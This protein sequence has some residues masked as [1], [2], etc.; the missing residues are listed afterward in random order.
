[1]LTSHGKE[2][3]AAHVYIRG[4]GASNGTCNTH[5]AV[6]RRQLHTVHQPG[7]AYTEQEDY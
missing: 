5:V 1:M 3:G 2:G 6:A 7:R 4:T